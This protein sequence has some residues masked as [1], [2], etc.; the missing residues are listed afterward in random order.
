MMNN[1]HSNSVPE[2]WA[3]LDP[4][5]NNSTVADAAKGDEMGIPN[6]YS[7]DGSTDQIGQSGTNEARVSNDAPNNRKETN[8][9]VDYGLM[10]ERLRELGVD[11]A[12]DWVDAGLIT[13]YYDENRRE[14]QIKS[15]SFPAFRLRR[16]DGIWCARDYYVVASD[17]KYSRSGDAVKIGGMDD[18]FICND[19]RILEFAYKAR[20]FG[21][22]EFIV[23]STQLATTLC[24]PEGRKWYHAASDEPFK[25]DCA[26]CSQLDGNDDLHDDITACLKFDEK[27]RNEIRGSS[28][29]EFANA[30]K[31]QPF[32]DA[33]TGE[34]MEIRYRRDTYDEYSNTMVASKFAFPF[35]YYKQEWVEAEDGEHKLVHVCWAPLRLMQ[36]PR[37]EL[38][39]PD[40][41]PRCYIDSISSVS[42]YGDRWRVTA[43]EIHSCVDG[44]YFVKFQIWQIREPF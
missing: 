16:A 29:C 14:M 36:F 19:G 17:A 18:E 30:I 34:I 22:G 2:Q 33:N 13:V 40:G 24:A 10:E 1:H 4:T 7:L 15:A 6:K 23:I 43:P 35:L 21:G 8:D 26:D 32:F 3:G 38:F 5:Q 41:L 27:R 37:G 9:M 44:D 31:D 39:V 12:G 25:C 42:N 20:E 28:F 11:G